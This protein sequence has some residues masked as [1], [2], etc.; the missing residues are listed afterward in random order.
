[1]IH[2]SFGT[3]TYGAV[4]SVA[5]TPV[6]TKFWM[7]QAFPVFPLESY[8]LLRL[9]KKTRSGVPL[10]GGES[11]QEIIGLP[12]RRISRLSVLVT[13][14]R[15]IAAVFVL[16]SMIVLLGFAVVSLTDPAF[17]GLNAEQK[18]VLTIAL[19]G[20]AGSVSLG[21][22]TC[23]FTLWTPRRERRIRLA[24]ARVLGIAADPA[25]VKT[26]F[27]Q[28]IAERIREPLEQL[29]PAGLVAVLR[30]PGD[31]DPKVL[32]LWLVHVRTQIADNMQ[33]LHHEAATDRILEALEIVMNQKAERAAGHVRR[34]PLD[35]SGER[36]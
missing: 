32:D 33:T 4:R 26:D 9:G 15:G 36:C 16:L 24:C 13:Y 7:L 21:L 29:A 6:V 2:V 23:L 20:L 18:N 27:A 5:R 34:Q 12:C 35:E 22:S 19:Y 1:M 25:H 17:Q 28:Q 10:L 30:R 11:H 31:F 14:V 8:Y 3:D